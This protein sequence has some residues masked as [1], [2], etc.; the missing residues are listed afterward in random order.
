[1]ILYLKLTISILEKIKI[2]D[3]S[4]PYGEPMMQKYNLYHSTGGEFLP[5]NFKFFDSLMKC[6]FYTDGKLSLFE[7]KKIQKIIKK[8]YQLFY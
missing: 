6:L 5:G 7:V 8:G 3:R 1:M 2:Y 4:V